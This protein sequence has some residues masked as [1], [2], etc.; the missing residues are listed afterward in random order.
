MNAPDTSERKRKSL[1]KPIAA[2]VAIGGL[3]AFRGID[4][5]G[6]KSLSIV[7]AALI[8][9]GLGLLGWGIGTLVDKARK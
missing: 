7:G 3:G 6:F 9:A 5:A 2:A 8:G 1:V 4:P